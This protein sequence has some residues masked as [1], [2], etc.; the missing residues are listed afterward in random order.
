MDD[1]AIPTDMNEVTSNVSY[2]Y[3]KAVDIALTFGPKLLL[4]ILVYFFH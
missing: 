1:I 2:L 3:D 4:A